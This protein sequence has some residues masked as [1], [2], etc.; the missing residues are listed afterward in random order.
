MCYDRSCTVHTVET[1]IDR[2]E[3]EVAINPSLVNNADDVIH[4]D[5]QLSAQHDNNTT[6]QS[7]LYLH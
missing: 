7:L 5:I 6:T 4:L 1:L 2:E 3:V